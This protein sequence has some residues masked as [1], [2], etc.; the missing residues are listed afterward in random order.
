MKN[1]ARLPA[2]AYRP[3]NPGETYIP[4]VPPDQPLPEVTSRSVAWGLIMAAVFTAAAAYLG[5]KIGQVFEAAIPIAILA[6]GI[7]GT[8]SRKSTILENVI[9]QSIGA[10]SG[11]VVAGAIFTIPGLYILKLDTSFLQIF[12]ASLFGGFL[13]ILFLIPLRRYFVAEQHGLLPFPEATATTEVLVTG[14]AG[15]EQAGI[16]LRAAAVGGLYDFLVATFGLWREVVSTRVIPWGAALADKAK[17]VVKLNAGAAVMGLG[18]IVGLRYASIIAAGS[19]VSWLVLIPAI[20][21]I[22]SHVDQAILP[23]TK[24]LAQLSAEEI[25]QNYVRHIGIGGIAMAGILGIIRNAKIIVQAFGLGLRQI[26]SGT[27]QPAAKRTERDIP[28]SVLVALI[29]VCSVAILVFFGT[30]VVDG[31]FF[32]LAATLLALVV[33]FLFTTVAARAIAIVGVNPVSGMTLM[34]LILSS[35]ILVKLGLKGPEGMV[36]ALIIG[37][38]VCTSLSMSGGFIT[39][40]KIGYWIGATPAQQERWKFLGTTVAALAVG[41]VILLLNE[42]YGFTPDRPG[43]MAAPQANAMAAVLNV[44]FATSSVPWG[45]YTAGIFMSLALELIGVPPLAFALGMYLPIELNT[46]VLVGGLIAHLVSSRSKDEEVNHARRERGTLIA[47]GFIAGGAIMGVVSAFLALFFGRALN[48]GLADKP[49]GE[50]LSIVLFTL[51]CLFTYHY[52][53]GAAKE[54]RTPNDQAS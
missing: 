14:E 52:A 50:I 29:A 10:A 35:V 46:P 6:V 31:W 53:K 2:N 42:V 16:L 36:S 3:L 40:L 5:L 39:D 34:T 19:F 18:Y 7:A 37:T 25:F 8:Y 9:I 13:G 41:A 24:P 48:T 51:L 32:A 27:A 15:G 47:S 33:S 28:M 22:G 54:S 49:I 44:L 26:F 30:S 12:L 1:A 4:F 38:V 17:L 20:W 45:L 11:V 23:A 21:Y 43:A